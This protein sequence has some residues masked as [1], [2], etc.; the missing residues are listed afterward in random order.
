MS[1]K[2]I[3]GKSI[4]VEL[5]AEVAVE[6]RRLTADHNIVP[7]LAVV[8]IGENPASMTYVKSKARALIEVGM[9]PF[10]HYLPASA[11]ETELLNLVA[12]L[13]AEPAVHGILVQLPLPPHI[14]AA[15]IFANIDP[16]K[17]VDGFHPLNAGRLMT[18]LPAL[19]PCTPVA[20]SSSIKTV[21]PSLLGVDAL[22]VGRSHIVGNPLS[23]VLLNEN[24]TVTVAH[25]HTRD[26]PRLL[27]PC[28]SSVRR[29]RLR[30]IHPRRLDQAGRHRDRRRHQPHFDGRQ[31]PYRRRREFRGSG[32]SRRRHHAGARRRRADDDRVPVGQHPARGMHASRPAGAVVVVIPGLL[33][34]AGTMSS[35]IPAVRDLI[36]H[37]RAE[38][39]GRA[40][41]RLAA[42]RAI[43]LH[44]AVVFRKRPDDQRFHRALRQIAARGG[45][46]A[47]AEAEPLEFRPQIKLVDLAVVIAGCARDCV[48]NWRS[49]RSC[50]RTA[51]ARC[52]CLCGWRFPTMPDRGD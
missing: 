47:A 9:R 31:I 17:D 3:D 16:D 42:E 33:L 48:R 1:A 7:G 2:I 13:N 10:D 23:Q 26:L 30:R 18:G 21:H 45:E 41:Y 44:G 6:T 12:K 22:M 8:L 37:A 50:R 43:E 46:Q 20:A 27:P 34:R 19:V 35:A 5:R 51:G 28:R 38:F 11:S 25:S 14:D 15:K 49:R 4:A 40:R 52:G 29:H 24:A 32:R 39:L 36:E